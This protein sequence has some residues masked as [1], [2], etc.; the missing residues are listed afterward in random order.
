MNAYK[1]I[2]KKRNSNLFPNLDSVELLL[3]SEMKRKFFSF[4]YLLFIS[5]LC[6]QNYK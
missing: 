3:H 4:A 5:Y 2:R 6:I 1:K